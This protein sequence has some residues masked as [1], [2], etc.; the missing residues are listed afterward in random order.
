[1]L[2]RSQGSTGRVLGALDTWQDVP[3]IDVRYVKVSLLYGRCSKQQTWVSVTDAEQAVSAEVRRAYRR[4]LI[5]AC[6]AGKAPSATWSVL[7]VH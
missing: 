7:R 2:G 5:G 1:M 4:T 3:D 6:C